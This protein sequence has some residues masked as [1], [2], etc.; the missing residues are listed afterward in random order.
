MSSATQGIPH[1]AR[2]T[3]TVKYQTD[4]K[5]SNLPALRKEVD[6]I[7]SAFKVDVENANLTNVIISASEVPQGLIV[8]TGNMYNFV[9]TK[10]DGKWRLLDK[11]E[12][13]SPKP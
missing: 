7:W 2:R 11:A 9:F 12:K 1:L 3:F 5:V 10:V 13:S 8:K 4:L 6:E